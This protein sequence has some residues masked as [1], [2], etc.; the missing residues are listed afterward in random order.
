MS[1]GGEIPSTIKVVIVWLLI[2]TAVFLG[3]QWYEREQFKPTII[4][5]SGLSGDSLVIERG[6]DGHYHLLVQVNGIDTPFMLDTGATQS[7][8]SSDFARKAKITASS[9][10]MFNTANGVVRGDIGRASIALPNNLI[11]IDGLPISIL[12][13]LDGNS[14]LGM[15]VLGKLK[16]VQEGKR[17]TLSRR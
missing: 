4:S 17:L 6:R 9:S 5:S 3:W 2:G 14:L 10:A 12:E 1:P 7:A 8:V 15:D 13:N 16:M 11:R